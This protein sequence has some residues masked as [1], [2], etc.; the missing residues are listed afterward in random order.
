MESELLHFFLLSL[1][2]NN[3][4]NGYETSWQLI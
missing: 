4:L 1:K 3:R 2:E